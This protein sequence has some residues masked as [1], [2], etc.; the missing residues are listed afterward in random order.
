[1]VQDLQAV[2]LRAPR[3]VPEAP[4]RFQPLRRQQPE[5]PLVVQDLQAVVV[6]VQDLQAVDPRAPRQVPVAPDRFQPLRQ[7]PRHRHQLHQRATSADV[8][9]VAGRPSVVPMVVVAVVD[10]V[11]RV[12]VVPMGHRRH[13]IVQDLRLHRPKKE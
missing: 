5:R 8:D 12:V 4:D 6:L 7:W 11:L 2:V 3:L 9:L 1:M 13:S 10:V